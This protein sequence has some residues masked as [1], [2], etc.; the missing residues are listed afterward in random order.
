MIQKNTYTNKIITKALIVIYEHTR[1]IKKISVFFIVL[2]MLYT[3][4][5]PPCCM[6]FFCFLLFSCAFL[7]SKML[8]CCM[9]LFLVR[10]WLSGSDQNVALIIVKVLFYFCAYQ[11]VPI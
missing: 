7:R 9:C 10:M 1:V 3:G 11:K 6:C 2:I 5:H 4:F 8:L